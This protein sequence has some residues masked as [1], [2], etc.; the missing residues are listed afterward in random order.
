[1]G[2]DAAA[3]DTVPTTAIAG[4]ASLAGFPCGLDVSAGVATAD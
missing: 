3:T 2:A 4:A 1:M